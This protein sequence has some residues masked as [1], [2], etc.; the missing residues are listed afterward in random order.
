MAINFGHSLERCVG[1]QAVG[2]GGGVEQLS[3]KEIGRL[4]LYVCIDIADIIFLLG[5]N[6]VPAATAL[7]RLTALTNTFDCFDRNL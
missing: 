1:G 5:V 2:V 4:V 3:F 7:R 6:A